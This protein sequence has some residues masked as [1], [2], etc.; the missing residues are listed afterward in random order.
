M[1]EDRKLDLI[2]VAGPSGS[3]K[4]TLVGLLLSRSPEKFKLSVSYT[5]RPPR[6]S[7]T[8]HKEYH[9]IAKEEFF[10]K[11]ARDEF[12]EYAEY[13]GNYYGTGAEY[14]R[15][16]SDGRV[17]ILE[18]EKEG[19][20]QIKKKDKG[21]R[22]KYIFLSADINE[23]RR[24]ILARGK[25]GEE[26]LGWRMKRAEDELEYG[27]SGAFDL[28]VQGNTAEDTYSQVSAY[29]SNYMQM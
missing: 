22:V 3:G 5:T 8:N 20:M 14:V 11:I 9:F 10:A 21:L 25:M 27:H 18:I 24:R 6:A 15:G 13:S 16:A 26:E 19:V 1:E 29:L 7:E 17:L 23:L 2:T 4:S 12:L 28:V